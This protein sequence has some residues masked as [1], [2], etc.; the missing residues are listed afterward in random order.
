M[1]LLVSRKSFAAALAA[2][3]AAVMILVPVGA[4][5]T[6]APVPVAGA[7]CDSNGAQPVQ[8]LSAPFA[9]GAVAGAAQYEFVIATDSGFLNPIADINT[10]NTRATLTTTPQP[11]TT[12]YWRVRGINAA[13]VPL[14]WS[15]TLHPCSFT[16]NWSDPPQL[17]SPANN[18]Q[19]QYPSPILLDWTQVEG[20]SRYKLQV[21][22]N[23]GLSSLAFS[24]DTTATQYSP[25]SRLSSG[26]YY[27]NVTPESAD[28]KQIGATSVTRLFTWDWP[29]TDT[30]LTVTDLDSSPEVFDPQF[31]WTPIPGASSY[32]I[33]IN[34]DGQNWAS[35]SKVCCDADI[36]ATSYSPPTSPP[37]RHVLL[38]S[39]G[40]GSQRQLRPVGR[41]AQQQLARPSRSR[42]ATTDRGITN[43]TMIGDDGSPLLRVRR[44]THRG[45]VEPDARC[46]RVRRR[47]RAV[48]TAAS[49]DYT[50]GRVVGADGSDRVDAAGQWIYG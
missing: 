12:Y 15:N 42:S 1:S 4:A 40:E 17:T 46:R 43:L 38:A 5:A 16:M 35:G 24:V 26:T 21:F 8:H 13:N 22:R 39:A 37:C 23:A 27:W 33:E 20:A 28:L 50:S 41:R 3:G 9:W 11:G 19:L 10:R 25:P 49:C 6:N 45:D 34:T 36:I 29:A 32:Q 47:C 7:L 31:S 2:V 18:G 30:E 14:A 44:P 48:R